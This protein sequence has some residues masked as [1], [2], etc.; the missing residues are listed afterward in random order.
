MPIC[1]RRRCRRMGTHEKKHSRLDLLQNIVITLLTVSAVM[2]FAATQ[3]S[4]LSQG[5]NLLNRW[6]SASSSPAA[7]AAEEEAAPL[8]AP[9]R[10][11]VSGTYGRYGSVTLSS[12]SEEFI[13]LA[14]RLGEALG[15]ARSFLSCESQD[16]MDALSQPSIFYDFWEALP[17]SV[18]A[19]LI[20]LPDL[21]AA[22]ASTNA[23]Q[24][25]VSA[26]DSGTVQL[27][28]W[29]GEGTYLRCG[30][31]IT[32]GDLENTISRYELGGAYF[33]FDYAENSETFQ[34]VFSRSLFLDPLPQLPQLS[35]ANALTDTYAVL[36]RLGFNPYTNSRYM[37]SG[38]TEVVTE[39]DQSVRL[40]P[41]GIIRYQGSGKSDLSIDAES[42]TPTL[43]E[44]VSGASELLNSLLSGHTGDAVLYLQWVQQTGSA[45]VLRFGYQ[46]GGV[47]IRFADGTCA[48]EV[49][50]SGTAVSSLAL[51]F[52]QYTAGGE[53]SLL[54]PLKQAISIAAQQEG[55]E[56]FIA[57]TDNGADT[58]SAAWL[59]E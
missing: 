46:A 35:V 23:R 10:V 8:S 30:T 44:A 28:L 22:I 45:T 26:S 58:A 53:A 42:E 31:A 59:L 38:G 9:V 55:K 19:E 49:V 32:A 47:P 18:L 24:L 50:L 40:L 13:P 43:W 52:R 20:S 4:S 7:A 11:A 6:F 29:D 2:L 25:V 12:G 33:A 51:C 36:T 34:Q 39:G 1:P 54:L 48:A 57:Y 16:F 15:S 14:T 17:L 3:I 56:L 5:S 27:L 21:P 41:E 37:E